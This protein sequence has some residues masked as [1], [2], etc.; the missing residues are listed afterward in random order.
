MTLDDK[1]WL[2]QGVFPCTGCASTCG[3]LTDTSGVFS[4][5]SGSSNYANSASCQWMIAPTQATKIT[6]TFT[7]FVTEINNDV[8]RV[9]QCTST[10]CQ[11]VQLVGELS[12]TYDTAQPQTVISTTGFLLVQFTSN[13]G[14]AYSGFTATWSST[15]AVSVPASSALQVSHHAAWYAVAQK[16]SPCVEQMLTR[17]FVQFIPRTSS[18][19]ITLICAI[20]DVQ[21]RARLEKK[22]KI[23]SDCTPFGREYFPAQDAHPHVVCSQLQVALCQMDL[24]LLPITQTALHATGSLL[25][26]IQCKSQ[27]L[28]QS[29]TLRA[30]VT[31]CGCTS[32]CR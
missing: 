7:E 3:T 19:A 17:G 6:I 21:G 15:V 26:Q 16:C 13:S 24:D 1:R 20:F 14:T 28:S 22:A 2:L 9:Y 32:A 18:V 31:A 8:V 30:A 29:S 27:S 11:S 10:A 5:G 12:G 25:L 4:D 23:F